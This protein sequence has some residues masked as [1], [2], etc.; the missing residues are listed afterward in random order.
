MSLLT[1]QNNSENRKNT[2]ILSSYKENCLESSCMAS[3]FPLICGKLIFGTKSLAKSE[4][5]NIEMVWHIFFHA[6]FLEKLRY[7][8]FKMQIVITKAG[9]FKF[10]F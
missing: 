10:K 4:Y 9:S 8:S 6:E 1:S 2:K 7:S 5:N 3:P